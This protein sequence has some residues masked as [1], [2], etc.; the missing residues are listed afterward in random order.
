[1][2]KKQVKLEFEVRASSGLIY[3]MVSTPSGLSSWFCSD[4]DIYNNVYTFRWDGEEQKA[5]LVKKVPNKSI[6]FH[7][8]GAPSDEYL[9]FEMVKDEITGDMALIITDFVEPHE[10][11]EFTQL[12]ETQVNDMKHALGC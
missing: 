8:L 11:K 3:Q 10:E 1:M 7:W 9:E 5:E 12:W 2:G 4:V 6:K